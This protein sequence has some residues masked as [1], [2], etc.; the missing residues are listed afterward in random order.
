MLYI[1]LHHMLI[2]SKKIENM[3]KQN[4]N[5]HCQDFPLFLHRK[6]RDYIIRFDRQ[7]IVRS[8]PLRKRKAGILLAV[9]SSRRIREDLLAS[10]NKKG[11]MKEW[12]EMNPFSLSISP[13]PDTLMYPPKAPFTRIIKWPKIENY[14]SFSPKSFFKQRI[15]IAG[16]LAALFEK[17]C[18]H[19]HNWQPLHI[20][21]GTSDSSQVRRVS[22][23]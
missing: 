22:L 21:S 12:N 1:K 4:S 6:I 3:W 13:S 17:S 10:P 11:G 5:F 16:F 23:V 20:L 14:S 9:P 15:F 2:R 7:N 8:R 18:S 19:V